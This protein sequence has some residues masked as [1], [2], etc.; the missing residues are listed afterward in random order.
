MR[1][2]S[3]KVKISVWLTLLMAL[4]TGL[5]MIFILVISNTV[6]TNTAKEQLTRTVRSNLELVEVTEGVP[7]LQSDFHYFQNGISCLVYSKNET[8]LAGQIPVSFTVTTNFQ[9]GIIRTVD[10]GN[11]QYLILDVWLPSDWEHGVWIRGLMEAPNNEEITRNLLIIALIAMPVFMLLAAFGSYPIAKRAFKPLES[12]TATAEAINEAKDLSGRIGLPPGRDEFSRLAADF[13]QM[14][15]RLERSFEAEK[16]F[17]ADASH[18]LRTPVSIIKGACEYAE[19]YDETEEDRKETIDMIHRQA[20]RMA[21]L[22]S[23]LLSMTR[24]EQG[25]EAYHMERLDLGELTQSLCQEEDWEDHQLSISTESKVYVQADCEL[26][27]RL[28]RNLVENGFKYGKNGGQ[29]WVTVTHTDSEALLSV[30]DDGI[31]IPEEA[32]DKIWQRFYQ[33]DPSRSS[34]EGAGLGLSMVEQ[35]AL[36]HGGYMTLEST[37]DVGSTFTLHLPL[38]AAKIK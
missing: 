33:V 26:L 2:V 19:K 20:D 35:I 10:S 13:D 30:K 16:Q 5:M 29:V 38:V 8:L 6:A 23:Q 21:N 24:M 17:T 3:V 4:L 25:A 11:S 12:I 1:N 7:K 34:E 31:G 22:I 9:N 28:V 27:S 37:I 14:F 18:E 15:E 32:K 36:I